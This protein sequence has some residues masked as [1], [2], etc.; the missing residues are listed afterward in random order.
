MGV[1][2][3]LKLRCCTLIPDR[4]RV[5]LTS[6]IERWFSCVAPTVNKILLGAE[7]GRPNRAGFAVRR[8]VDPSLYLALDGLIS[9][10]EG[11]LFPAFSYLTWRCVKLDAIRNRA[12]FL[13]VLFFDVVL[14]MKAQKFGAMRRVAAVID[15]VQNTG[16]WDN[17]TLSR[18]K[19]LPKFTSRI[20]IKTSLVNA[21][22]IPQGNLQFALEGCW[23]RLQRMESCYPFIMTNFKHHASV[24]T[25]I[26]LIIG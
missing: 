17:A 20:E 11:A 19:S 5:M 25:Q 16:I 9:Y 18:F 22:G 12:S 7:H 2:E 8:A 6:L 23:R 26:Q 13:P 1:K 3:P 15:T 10:D 24:S 14:G 4:F 21:S